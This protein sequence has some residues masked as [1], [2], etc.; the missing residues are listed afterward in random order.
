MN[1]NLN[2][3]E[4]IAV[5]G[6]AV[7]L[8]LFIISQFIIIPVYEK[9]EALMQ[10]VSVKKD[11]L[12][13]MKILRSEYLIMKEKLDASQQG[14]KKRPANFT[15]FSFLDRLAGD[16]GLKDHIAYMKP[17]TSIKE[18]SGLKISRVELKLQEVTLKDL[19]A[20]LFKVETSKNMVIVKRLSITK[21]GKDTGRVTAVLQ[22]ETFES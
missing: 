12:L 18:E 16:T 22:V 21:T 6:A 7:F 9:R 20:Y 3:R 4:K 11:T 13:D 5:T 1:L 2:K 14:L 8:A 19:T 17:S 15:L 10:Q